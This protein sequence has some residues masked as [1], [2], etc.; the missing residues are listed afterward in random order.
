MFIEDQERQQIVGD[1]CRYLVERSH[2]PSMMFDSGRKILLYN[3]AM[4]DLTGFELSELHTV[5]DL[6]KAV[7]PCDD[8]RAAFENI[9]FNG[10]REGSVVPVREYRIVRKD[11]EK[12]FVEA[13]FFNVGCG[14]D[15]E[16]WIV[17]AVDVSE[18]RIY[19][20]ALTDTESEKAVIL[21]NLVELVVYQD[22]DQ[23][24]V[25]S[26]RAASDS[27]SMTYRDIV[28]KKCYEIWHSRTEPCVGCP[29]LGALNTGKPGE[30]QVVSPD[31]RTWIIKGY[32]VRDN[33]GRVIG[34]VE[35]TRDITLETLM[36][37]ELRET[38]ETLNSVVDWI[39]DVVFRLDSD[40][41]ISYVSETV[42]QRGYSAD[43]LIG[44]HI[45][46]IIHPED[47]KKVFEA[48]AAG[49]EPGAPIEPGRSIC[50]G[51]VGRSGGQ[52][53]IESEHGESV[54]FRMC[55]S[56][57][58][59][60]A[61]AKVESVNEYSIPEKTETILFAEDEHSVRKLV[62]RVLLSKGYNVLEAADGVEALELAK[63]AGPQNID[64]L[65]TDVVMEHMTGVQ[66][67]AEIRKLNSA[68]RVLYISGN[69]HDI[70]SRLDIGCEGN[71][72]LSK[73]FSV[74]TLIEKVRE[75]LDDGMRR[76]N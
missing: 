12:R 4:R 64:L 43:K 59:E 35:I 25:W 65:L 42:S 13:S 20:K 61:G 54:S 60:D 50:Y 32:P 56:G 72:F 2:I 22:A 28:G 46:D 49:R 19:R 47:L 14:N 18:S 34:A 5:D 53:R 8:Y 52:I 7:V 66:L 17:Q 44:M 36:K 38:A 16:Y 41:R 23:N 45:L 75:M 29:V 73:P 15:E 58:M 69:T 76:R 10:M 1:P 24:V 31:G 62:S 71:G 37:T 30:M 57:L 51:I 39:R 40:S 63:I 48:F 27:V 33:N 26:N 74:S 11:G 70:L 68:I 9:V 6:L 21:D 67:A 55:L 3:D